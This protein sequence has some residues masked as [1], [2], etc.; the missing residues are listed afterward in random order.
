[1]ETE[2]TIRNLGIVAHVDAGKTTLT[3]DMLFLSGALRDAGSVDKGTSSSDGLEVEKRRG[4]SVRASTRSFDWR[5]VQI[6]L[7]DT[8]G[9]A[10]F[11]AEVERSLRVLDCAVLVLSAVEGVQAQTESL[12][13]ALEGRGIPVIFFVNKIDRMGAD[14]AGV[15]EAVEREFSA[16]VLPLSRVE[17]EGEDGAAVQGVLADMDEEL[18]ERIAECDDELLGRYLE[19]EEVSLDQVQATLGR[20]VLER[21]LFP[22]LCGAAKYQVGI[23]ELL[24]AVVDYFPAA[25]TDTEGPV[26]GVVFRL[27]HDA[28]IG[29]MAGVRLYSGRLQNRASLVNYTAG[30]EE[31]I[32]QIKKETTTG[33]R[34]TGVLEAGDIG[35]L[36]GMPEAR[37]GDI[38]GDP[39]PVPDS[40][41]LGEPLLAVQVVARDPGDTTA[42]AQALQQLSSED[43]H[44]DFQW[45]HDERELHVKIMGAIQTEILTEILRT[46]FELEAEFSEATVVYREAPLMPGVGADSYTMPKPCWGVVEFSLEP[47]ERGSGVVYRSAVP[48]DRIARK[49]Q[50]EIA[51]AVPEALKQGPKGWEATDVEIT[52]VG[53][54]DHVLHS[55]PGDFIMATHMA[56]MKGLVNTETKLLEPML[57]LTVRAPDEFIGKVASDIIERRGLIEPATTTAGGVVLKGRVPLATGQDYAA[58]L[59]SLTGGRGKLTAVFDGYQDCP[60]GEGVERGYKGISPLDRSKYIL[61]MRGAITLSSR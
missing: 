53:G 40:Y 46:R 33:T 10:D 45:F 56:L 7:I 13:R 21:A 60:V 58:R 18:I 31:K 22:L 48:T 57:A 3:E 35:L 49:Y 6:N 2:R 27:E 42:L 4:I 44:L 24:D 16:P 29:R 47:G 43:P 30:R 14:H 51:A 23:G 25:A 50:N 41:Q 19:G 61:H 15:I 32:T 38:L 37:I 17:R 20:A 28:R 12:W 59:G 9:H 11:A 1:M 5:G 55:R 39:G 52:L 26:S 54:S 36:C 34:D 8:P